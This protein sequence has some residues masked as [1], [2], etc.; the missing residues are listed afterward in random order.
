[1]E[2]NRFVRDMI[3]VAALA[4]LA[5]LPGSSQAADQLSAKTVPSTLAEDAGIAASGSV[6]DTLKACLARIP[7]DATA[8]QRMIAEQSCQRDEATRQPIQAVPGR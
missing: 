6:E 1:M 3:M 2:T 8:G 5:W 4:L 7:T